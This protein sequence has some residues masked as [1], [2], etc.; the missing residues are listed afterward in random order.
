LF[1]PQNFHDVTILPERIWWGK[2]WL[3]TTI[4]LFVLTGTL[5]LASGPSAVQKKLCL[6]MKDQGID[7]FVF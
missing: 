3:V 6:P 5:Q 1:N 7:L 4:P 2:G